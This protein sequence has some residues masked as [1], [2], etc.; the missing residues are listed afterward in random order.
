LKEI[1]FFRN[2]ELF[3]FTCA[4]FIVFFHV[5]DRVLR[6]LAF[7]CKKKHQKKS[8]KRNKIGKKKMRFARL[9]IST[10]VDNSTPRGGKGEL[11]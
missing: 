8:T 9:D 5:F 6:T 7:F 2:S 1:F 10:T 3:L 11:D 4:F